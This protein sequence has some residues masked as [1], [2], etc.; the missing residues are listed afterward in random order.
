MAKKSE[1]AIEASRPAF[2]GIWPDF[3]ELTECVG[4]ATYRVRVPIAEDEEPR[5]EVY[6]CD[7]HFAR[8]FR[9]LHR[10][11]VDRLR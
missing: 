5:R 11:H 8:H 7:A 6:L 3:C 2:T 4:D 1:T 10:R 9:T